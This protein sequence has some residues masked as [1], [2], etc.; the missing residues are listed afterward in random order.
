MRRTSIAGGK[1]ELIGDVDRRASR[2][3][4]CSA[5]SA[6]AGLNSAFRELYVILAFHIHAV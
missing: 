5:V 3:P 1:G 6:T 4:T 2:D